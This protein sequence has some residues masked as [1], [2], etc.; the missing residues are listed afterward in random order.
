MQE[1]TYRDGSRGV[2]YFHLTGNAERDAAIL[3]GEHAHA[4]ARGPV[5]S[6]VQRPVRPN[7]DLC[8]CGSGMRYTRCKRCKTQ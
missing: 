1:A 5:E 3:K 2:T 4:L 7:V 8:P 6:I